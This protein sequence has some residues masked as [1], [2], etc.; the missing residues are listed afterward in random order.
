MARPRVITEGQILVA[1]REV[2]TERGYA[3]ASTAEIARRAGVAEGTLF[4]RY[5]TKAQLFRAA[6][7]LPP[8]DGFGQVLAAVGRGEL[9]R[10][11]ED[12]VVAGVAALTELLPGLLAVWSNRS[13]F[14][15]APPTDVYAEEVVEVMARFFRAEMEL[16]R[17]RRVD[18][19]ALGHLFAGA[20]WSYCI[21]RNERSPAPRQY[22]RDL[23]A[24]LWTGIAP[25]QTARPS[26]SPAARS[27]SEPAPPKEHP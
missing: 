13:L 2:F 19:Q 21:T 20:I 25:P 15:N 6:L 8:L 10:T 22:A 4:H 16:G 17:M 3:G 24:V 1:A 12:F 27:R 7:A 9:H 5:R 18:E 23:V 26:G 11:L 14:P